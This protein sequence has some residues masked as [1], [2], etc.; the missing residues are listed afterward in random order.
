M[1]F[2]TFL[3]MIGLCCMLFS[4]LEAGG[5][6]ADPTDPTPARQSAPPAVEPLTKAEAAAAAKSAGLVYT[7]EEIALALPGVFENLRGYEAMRKITLEN[8]VIPAF[9]FSPLLPGVSSRAT[10]LEEAPYL[11]PEVERPA[12]LTELHFADI[13]T[14]ASL[15]KSRKVSCVELAELSLARLRA[16]DPTLLCVV[17]LTEERALQTARALD[18]ELAEGK[19][20]GPLHGI[21]YGAK[22]LFSARG[23]GTTWGAKP[24]EDQVIDEDAT[25]IEKLEV[26]GAVLVAKLSLGALAMGDIW[27]GGKTRNPFDPKRGSS[28]SSA[29]SASA[30]AAGCVPFALGTETLGSIISPGRRCGNSSIRPTFGRVS[31][32]GGMA[33]SWTMDKVGPIARSMHDAALV[34]SVIAGPDGEDPTVVDLPCPVPPLLDPKG[35]RIGV[36]KGAFAR[37]ARHKV[38][39]DEIEALGAEIVEIELPEYPVWEMMVILHAEAAAAFDDLTRSGVD[40]ELTA[41]TADAWPNL[42]RI[43]RLIPA[44]E[45]IRAS[46]LRTLL[47][48]DMHTLMGQVDLFVVPAY[49]G[50]SLGITNLT[51]HPAAIAPCG[52]HGDGRPYSVVFV[53][54]LFDE[55]RLAGF[56]RAW[57]ESTGH[58]KNHPK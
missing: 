4:P 41:Q 48:R 2:T 53:G 9:T 31:R 26:A 34:L 38:V 46:R 35:W 10:P 14:L 21:P 57:Q 47:A 6:P 54:Q 27:F 30:V 23:A 56:V 43:A 52:A 19:W 50:P 13:P 24:F 28:G 15:V 37:S 11:L 18:A 32:H 12:D 22:D 55:P 7:D 16:L 39:L 25:V 44:V 36:P 8:S 1:A 51:G 58:H 42:F 45:Y 20:R 33:L 5:A 40:D 49:D 3:R 17:S 29:G